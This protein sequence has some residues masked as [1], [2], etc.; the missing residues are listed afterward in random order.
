MGYFSI[1]CGVLG[2]LE[3]WK[4]FQIKGKIWGML[5]DGH[6]GYNTLDYTGGVKAEHCTEH[7]QAAFD[8]LHNDNFGASIPKHI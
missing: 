8:F 2:G 4:Y 7:S 1:N 5:F 6:D 3:S